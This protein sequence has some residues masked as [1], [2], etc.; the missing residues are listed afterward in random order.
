MHDPNLGCKQY[1]SLRLRGS[2][3][4]AA[5]ADETPPVSAKGI[6]HR[7]PRVA[8]GNRSVFHQRHSNEALP[9]V[10]SASR[11]SGL[12]PTA[13][14]LLQDYNSQHVLTGFKAVATLD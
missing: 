10:G 2:H 7:Q 8:I 6:Y 14:Q 12:Q 5:H 3:A 9:P 4:P 13:L 11:W 1:A